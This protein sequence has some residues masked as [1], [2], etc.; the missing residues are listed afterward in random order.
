MAE[1]GEKLGGWRRALGPGV[2]FTGAAVGVSHLVQSTR[3]GAVYGFAL[4][5]VVVAANLLKYPAF[6]FGPHY[7][8]ATNTSLLEGYRR[9]GRWALAVYALLTL[10]T[11]FTVL[12]AVT[13]VTAGIAGFLLGIDLPPVV[14]SAI[15]LFLCG[16]LVAVGRYHWLDRVSKVVVSV[17]ALSTLVAFFASLPAVD[18]GAIRV[19]PSSEELD[20]AGILFIAALIG[21]MP[22]AID[23]AVWQSLW[24][25]AREKDTGHRATL[26]ESSFDFHLGYWGTA[27]L[28]LCFLALGA[29]VMHGRGVELDQRPAVFASQIVDLYVAT[30]GEW[31]RPIIGTCALLTMFSTTLTV[32][33]GFP[34]AL[35]VLVARF[36]GP[37]Q[38]GGA[39]EDRRA[40]RSVYWLSVVLLSLG[41]LVILQLLLARL[42]SLVDVATTLSFLTAPI[43]AWLNHRAVLGPEVPSE[44]RPAPW[45][46]AA[47]WVG[48]V[49]LGS[50][51]VLYLVLIT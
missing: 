29:A 41:A 46:V 12:A 1:S 6:R 38:P 4:V 9:Q 30:L 42:K 22:S 32:L 49:G 34:R 47:S 18:W 48:I 8:A 36:R 50:F 24:T 26:R 10:G 14:V 17:L 11:M 51:A 25:L 20:P 19:V 40:N 45:L 21:W 23:V 44:M 7:A 5:L 28:A 39:E 37:E 27:V 16:G 43:L 35:S 3:A 2:L 13:L 33:D 15:V 31:S